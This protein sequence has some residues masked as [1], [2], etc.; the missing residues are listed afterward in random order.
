[1]KQAV[2]PDQGG[3]SFLALARLSLGGGEG[4][5]GMLRAL[6]VSILRGR[7]PV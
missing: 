5:P 3:G 1:M 2:R 4:V 6:L 7:L